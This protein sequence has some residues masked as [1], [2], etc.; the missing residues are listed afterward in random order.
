MSEGG[1]GGRM[2][3]GKP[4]AS[5]SQPPAGSE[6]VTE[7]LPTGSRPAGDEIRARSAAR[8]PSS[9]DV[10]EALPT[11]STAFGDAGDALRAG[12]QVADTVSGAPLQRGGASGAGA[13][14]AW[15]AGAGDR[16]AKHAEAPDHDVR[17]VLA[18]RPFRQLWLSLGLSS[19][20]DWLGLLA[21]TA[22]AGALGAKS[23][24]A[25]ANLAVSVV[26][27]LRLAP[28]MLFGPIAGVAAD[29][30]DRKVNMVVGDVL[31]CAL[32]VSI[33]VVGTLWWLFVAT[34]LIEI[35]GLFWM[36]AKDATVPNLVPRERL[37]AANQLSLA[38]TY[39]TAPFAALLF[40]ALALVSGVLDN[41]VSFFGGSNDLALYFNALTYL[42]AAVVVARLDMPRHA[43]PGE[44][45]DVTPAENAGLWKT[46]TEGWAFIG[47]TRLIRGLVVGMLG[48]FAAG[49]FVIGVA[50]TFTADLG[51][52]SAG[53]GVLFASVFTGLA[54]GMWVGP[55]LLADLPRWRLFG[56]AIITAGL[57]L[58]LV[59][60]ISNIVLAALFTLGLG[61]GAGVA[62][63][64]GY[65]MLGLE[66]ADEIRGRTFA[67]VQSGARV[68]LVAVM[69]FAPALAAVIGTH[70]F[71]L[72]R[73]VTLTYNGTA[74]TL[75]FAA[76][77]A[78][79]IGIL[80]YRQMDDGSG[81]SLLEDLVRAWRRRHVAQPF[82]PRRPHPGFFLALEGGDGA[83]KS[84]QV[85]LLEGWLEDDL[86][87]DVV[88]TREPGATPQGQRI[89]ELLLHGDDMPPRA[90]AL[91]FA[92][93]RAHHVATVVR[94]ALDRGAVVVTDRFADS[95]IAYQ[96]AGRE[97]DSDEVAQLSRWAAEGL[98]PDLTVVLD[99]DPV[100]GRQRRAVSPE[101]SKDD[102][103]ESEED[104]FHDRV[105]EHFLALARRHPRRYLVVDATGD[106]DAVQKQIRERLT[107]MLPP[108]PR[109]LAEAEEKARH[110][111]EEKARRA[112]EEKARREA[113]EKARREAEEQARCEA[114]EN[115]R[116]EAE[117][118]A[119]RE[120]EE[121]AR[122][123][124]EEQ[125][126]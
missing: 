43:Q 33:A 24:Y 101:R 25:Q 108:S 111:A 84:T 85:G 70:H 121:Q 29:K 88:L 68:V 12:E 125:A 99:V 2:D 34:V 19:F 86:G 71:V 120:A 23:G 16:Y 46:M 117:E 27:I 77:L 98:W 32:F 116:R 7:A 37:E 97:L 30:L 64:T 60:L 49:G 59:A 26:L 41:F 66:V 92:A 90:E 21:T 72:T 110:E 79:G 10:T 80:A 11:G 50:P 51:A 118:K 15:K 87:H 75:L 39:G 91:L 106:V 126:R 123:E 105:R 102:R 93:D 89:R 69:A 83:G 57:F 44:T 47:T 31:R 94:P 58:V 42:V 62:W 78:I 18:I 124:A 48:A 63:V 17:G 28:A 122:R 67:F 95:S 76:L 3:R 114:E 8:V 36:P 65:T 53:Y 45:T 115:A 96:G 113:E 20:G 6:D 1:A 52:G 38:T 74:F 81:V 109:H 55:R 107:A 104:E 103:M 13:S 73:N 61:A 4:L 40:S 35:I 100:T 112:A 14:A 56:L 9:D 5:S 22:M 54:C 119:R 82:P